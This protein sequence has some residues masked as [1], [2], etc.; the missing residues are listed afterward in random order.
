MGIKYCTREDVQTAL[1]M[2]S[3]ARD[4][5]QVDRLIESASRSVE[6][7]CHRIFYPSIDTR[8]FD[9]PNSQM[10]TSWRLWLDA[11]ELISASAVVSG[12]V[13]LTDYFLEP[14][15]YGPPYN[16]IELNLALTQ[17]FSIGST[18]QRNI[19]VTGLYGHSDNQ[20]AVGALSGAVLA[21][22]AT[23][24]LT[25]GAKV[26]VGSLLTIGTERLEV[27][28]RQMVSTGYTMQTDLATL[29]SS[30]LFGVTD[31]TKFGIG[32]VLLIDAER[33][34]VTDIAG[35][36]LIVKRGWD[37]S[38]LAA[39][40]GATIY[41]S[42]RLTVSRGVLGTADASHADAAAVTAWLV[43][44]PVRQLTIAEALDA[45]EQEN[46]AY[47]RVVGSGDHVRNAAGA[48]IDNLR[49]RTYTS[50]GRKARQRV[51]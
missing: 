8:Y 25:S 12:G 19:A 7:L 15:N 9:W 24:T 38:V 13:A 1:D 3:T 34:L 17:G 2:R 28:G 26:G 21:A 30:V 36:N 6:G 47:A 4:D 29:N 27:T 49:D 48:G 32:E 42:R 43:P 23:V 33:V 14:H 45:F 39:H 37:G 41:A 10:G 40:T 46:S 18:Y 35:N 16:R 20:I 5:D 51:I 11:N 22:D 50:H 31:G 44:G